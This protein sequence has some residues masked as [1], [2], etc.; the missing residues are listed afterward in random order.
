MKLIS[1]LLDRG[2]PAVSVDVWPNSQELQWDVIVEKIRNILDMG[3]LPVLH[4]DAI[5]VREQCCILSGYVILL[6]LCKRL[7]PKYC[8][9]VTNVEGVFKSMDS[10]ELIEEMN[11]SM[12]ES[13]NVKSS[14][15]DFDVTGGM[16]AKLKSAFEAVEYTLDGRI[17]IVGS[18]AQ[19]DTEALKFCLQ[20]SNLLKS[21]NYGTV[22][23]KR[24]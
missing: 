3:M 22:I 1:T 13:I 9:F 20:G 16:F 17:Y 21:R 7:R 10:K 18:P 4:G 11:T 6:E 14:S 23:R 8:C 12:F 24:N 5:V 2:I 15:S 19:V